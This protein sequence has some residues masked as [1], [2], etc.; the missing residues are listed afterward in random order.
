MNTIKLYVQSCRNDKETR[1]SDNFNKLRIIMF[2]V[3]R[4]VEKFKNKQF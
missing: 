2:T 4:K 3:L 1:Q